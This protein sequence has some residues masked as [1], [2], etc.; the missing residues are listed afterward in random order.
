MGI[1]LFL[2]DYYDL[3]K[4]M[5]NNEAIILNEKIIQLT[6]QQIASTLKGSKM[7][8]NSMFGRLQKECFVEQRARGK[9]VL[10]EKADKSSE[11]KINKPIMLLGK[12]QS[13]KTRVYTGVIALAF[14]NGFD[15]V[16]ILSKNS[17]ALI[18]QTVSQMK[19]EFKEFISSYEVV[20]SDIM[21]SNT[22]ISGYQLE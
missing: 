9:Y 14:D 7:K 21:K 19:K 1:N 16:F 3:L 5:H 2:N 10:T 4:L 13:G 17:K 8:V 15:M 20:V 22:R 11:E 6:Q 12:I 18:N